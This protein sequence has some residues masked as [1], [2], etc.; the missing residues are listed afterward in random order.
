[1]VFSVKKKNS[2]K[3]KHYETDIILLTVRWYL[4]YNLSF[5]ELVEMIEEQ[6]LSIGRPTTMRWVHQ[7]RPELDG[8]T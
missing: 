5:R 6:G 7:Y 2:F 4:Q 8:V 3:W 1:M